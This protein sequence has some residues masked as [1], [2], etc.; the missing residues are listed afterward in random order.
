MLWDDSRDLLHPHRD[1]LLLLHSF[2]LS[3]LLTLL[4]HHPSALLIPVN[5]HPKALAAALPQHHG[6]LSHR[7]EEELCPFHGIIIIIM[8]AAL[9][10]LSSSPL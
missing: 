7:L 8:A 9:L 5:V 10:S 4:Q 6:Y 1:L 3:L 2:S